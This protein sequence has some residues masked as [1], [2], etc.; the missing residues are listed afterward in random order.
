MKAYYTESFKDVTTWV[1][2][3]DALLEHF[4]SVCDLGMQL[5][6]QQN[7]ARMLSANGLLDTA[8]TRALLDIKKLIRFDL[9][10]TLGQ[11][12]SEYL[13]LKGRNIPA[14]AIQ[15]GRWILFAC[16]GDWL[17]EL[18]GDVDDTYNFDKYAASLGVEI[19]YG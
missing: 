5:V 17:P 3:C 19:I 14:A 2:D 1:A 11:V 15:Q 13:D 8:I 16:G 7:D 6:S 12:V 4:D 18:V 9:H 10:S